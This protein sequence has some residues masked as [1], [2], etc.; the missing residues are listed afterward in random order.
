MLAS[1]P[2]PPYEEGYEDRYEDG[3]RMS[4]D[5]SLCRFVPPLSV[6]LPVASLKAIPPYIH[7]DRSF[8]FFD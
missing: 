6:T 2:K 4:G 8:F 5:R 3:T 1:W 7:R